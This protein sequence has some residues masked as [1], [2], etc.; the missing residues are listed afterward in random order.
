MREET[1]PDASTYVA[2]PHGPGREKREKPEKSK[3]SKDGA[4]GT[5]R[6]I[7]TMFRTAYRTHLD[8]SGLADTKANIMISI[9]GIIISIIAA[10][11]AGSMQ[12]NPWLLLPASVFLLTCVTSLVFSVLAAMPRIG[13]KRS[14][15]PSERTDPLTSQNL[16]FFGTFVNLPED[17]FVEGIKDLMRQTGDLYAAMAKDLYSLGGVLARKYRLIR[18]AYAVF[19]SGLVVGVILLVTVLGIEAVQG[20]PS[21]NP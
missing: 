7:E 10:T 19:M 15:P 9:N 11:A 12:G 16:L 5:K 17:E 14:P 2:E 6:G 21:L 13:G 20:P 3:Q 8:L 1:S 18:A 4:S